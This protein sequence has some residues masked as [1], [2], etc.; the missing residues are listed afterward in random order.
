MSVPTSED[1]PPVPVSRPRPR[2]LWGGWLVS[3]LGF[4]LGGL[5]AI[6]LGGVDDVPVAILG[7][8]AAGLVIGTGQGLVL[9]RVWGRVLVPWAAASALGL[10]VGLAIGSSVVGFGTAAPDLV[11][12]GLI[13]GLGVGVAQAAVLGGHLGRGAGATWALS[14]TVL[15]PLGWMVTQFAGVQVSDRFAV[16]GASGALV[17]SALS[18]CVLVALIATRRSR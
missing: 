15:W 14:V 5:P 7:G 6:A 8:V 13:C 12:Q 1:A 9:R 2:R 4:P 17:F 3:F 11:I 10:G 16:F 18:G